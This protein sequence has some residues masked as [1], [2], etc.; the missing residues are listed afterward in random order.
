MTI[1][2]KIKLGMKVSHL[3]SMST[4]TTT[5]FPFQLKATFVLYKMDS[6]IHFQVAFFIMSELCYKKSQ[7]QPSV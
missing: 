5:F 4:Q 7:C 2:F 3:L 1:P 6:A